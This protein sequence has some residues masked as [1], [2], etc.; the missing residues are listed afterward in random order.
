MN[1][2]RTLTTVRVGLWRNNT[3]VEIR[4][5]SVTPL[6]TE[7]Q[8]ESASFGGSWG[9]PH[10]THSPTLGRVSRYPVCPLS[11]SVQHHQ[12]S[13][14]NNPLT[15]SLQHNWSPYIFTTVTFWYIYQCFN[16]TSYYNYLW[17]SVSERPLSP[18]S[19]HQCEVTQLATTIS[20]FLTS[21]SVT[22][23]ITVMWRR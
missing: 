5:R 12:L 19:S 4:E 20:S 23:I 11:S 2:N 9:S 22:T 21:L 17:L 6:F 18:A 14:V 8:T 1:Y 15:T 10:A 13:H 7:D 3:Y 16:T